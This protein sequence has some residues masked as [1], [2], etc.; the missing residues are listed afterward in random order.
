M[1]IVRSR[2]IEL[3]FSVEDRKLISRSCGRWAQWRMGT[4]NRTSRRL[5]LTLPVLRRC[6]SPQL[7]KSVQDGAWFRL[8]Q[9]A[10]LDD[11]FGFQNTIVRV[12]SFTSGCTCHPVECRDAALRGSKFDCLDNRK[13]IVGHVF[14]EFLEDTIKRWDE[15]VQSSR[16]EIFGGEVGHNAYMTCMTG[17][18]GLSM[19]KFGYINVL[20][21][22]F[23][24][25]RNKMWYGW[26]S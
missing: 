11:D 10:I 13:S 12:R 25:S 4:V 21:W 20:P 23:L 9:V 5:A 8:V 16:P 18:A 22:R 2:A 6:F 24:E 1:D 19:F 14:A 17:Q 7:F 26:M 3:D 15:L